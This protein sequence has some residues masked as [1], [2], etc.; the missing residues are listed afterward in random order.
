MGL[1]PIR[2]GYQLKE[3]LQNHPY[4]IFTYDGIE[5]GILRN[6]AADAQEE[7]FSEKKT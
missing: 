6:S 1:S 3:Q 2:N 5:R 7:E 4:C